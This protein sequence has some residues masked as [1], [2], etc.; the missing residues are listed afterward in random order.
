MPPIHYLLPR[1]DSIHVCGV[2]RLYDCAVC[3]FCCR[4]VGGASLWC[5][6]PGSPGG[7]MSLLCPGMAARSPRRAGTP[8]P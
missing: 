8:P 3:G 4:P 5:A 2:R 7:G 1:R 6:G